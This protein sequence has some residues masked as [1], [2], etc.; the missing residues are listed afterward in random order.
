MRAGHP[1]NDNFV[2]C[3]KFLQFVHFLEQV[4]GEIL[5]MDVRWVFVSCNQLKADT[6]L[7]DGVVD[8]SK[9]SVVGHP[10]EIR[11]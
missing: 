10:R 9:K 8:V 5:G 7:T 2:L 4:E 1:S 3:T 11:L 6:V